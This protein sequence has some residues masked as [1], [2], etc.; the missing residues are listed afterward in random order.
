MKFFPNA[1][2]KTVDRNEL[3]YGNTYSRC[4]SLLET[5]KCSNERLVLIEQ[6][7]SFPNGRTKKAVMVVHRA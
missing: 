5:N 4:E 1:D 6:T 2:I 7:Y 3:K